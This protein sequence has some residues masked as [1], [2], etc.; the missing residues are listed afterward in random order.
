MTA[1]PLSDEMKTRLAKAAEESRRIKEGLAE[2]P[3]LA[4]LMVDIGYKEL[5]RKLHP[6]VGGS[7][8]EMARLN[9][10][11]QRLRRYSG[12]SSH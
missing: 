1:M 9:A 3:R 12:A 6:D 11:R 2:I 7:H 10:A 4:N 8:E 5:A